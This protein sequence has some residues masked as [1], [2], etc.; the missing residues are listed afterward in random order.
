MS[1]IPDNYITSESGV[2]EFSSELHDNKDDYEFIA[3]LE[4]NRNQEVDLKSFLQKPEFEYY[5]KGD[6]GRSFNALLI[7]LKSG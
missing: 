3:N 7:L 4:D 1:K 2:Y 5:L 6:L